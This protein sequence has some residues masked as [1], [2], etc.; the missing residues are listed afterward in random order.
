VRKREGREL[1]EESLRK[2]KR[3]RQCEEESVWKRVEEE[4]V[5]K[6]V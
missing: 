1:K 4:I 2:K 3:R 6:R 5:R